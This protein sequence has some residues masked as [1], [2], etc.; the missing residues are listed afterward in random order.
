MNAVK[1]SLRY[2]VVTLALA[3]LAVAVGV[4]RFQEHAPHGRSDHHH[5]DGAG[6]GPLSWSHGRT[7]RE[8]GGQDRRE[9]H[10][11]VPGGPEGKD[12]FHKPSRHLRHECGTG[13]RREDS[14]CGLG[15]DPRRD[16]RNAPPSNCPTE[17]ADPSSIRTSGDTVAMLV[18]VPRRALRVPRA[19]R[20]PGQDP[21][22]A[23][24]HPGCGKAC[25]LRG[26]ERADLDHEQPSSGFRNTSSTRFASHRRSSKRNTI[27]SSGHFEAD[28]AKIPLRTTG[29]F[30]TEGQIRNVLVD[31][32]RT[33]QPVYIR[34]FAEVERR[35]QDPDFVVRYD[36]ER[37]LLLS[38][39]M[40]K[41]RNIVQLGRPNPGG[42]H[43]PE[44]PFA[45]RMSQLDPI[46]NQPARGRE[47][48][49]R[50]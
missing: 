35:Y 12:L 47:T 26:A 21:G 34:D 42:F 28:R 25:H 29:L 24:H 17:S 32:S 30:T 22:R 50:N 11:Q 2:P 43:A 49:R 8:A 13:R 31:V 9:T 44:D 38:I 46:A 10:L 48:H 14:R 40:Q 4:P 36:G 27:E 41:G 33:G 37:S 15:Q 5:P 6:Y 39:E 19:S 3:A 20:L 18:A 7:G 1:A 45:P 23:A 16:E